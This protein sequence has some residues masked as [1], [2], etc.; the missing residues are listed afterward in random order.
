MTHNQADAQ[1]AIR[2]G[3]QS[4]T[5]RLPT[6]IPGRFLSNNDDDLPP[7][8][9]TDPSGP[10]S[11]FSLPQLPLSSFPPPRFSPPSLEEENIPELG[12]IDTREAVVLQGPLRILGYVLT[13][14]LVTSCT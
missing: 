9:K 10:S 11:T 4:T 6:R 2:Q 12:P 5:W 13:P 1:G 7:Y 3:S 14:K 8:S